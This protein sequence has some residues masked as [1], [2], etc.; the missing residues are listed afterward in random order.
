MSLEYNKEDRVRGLII[1]KRCLY[2]SIQLLGGRKIYNE[3]YKKDGEFFKLI[4]SE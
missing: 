2:K 1:K 3:I 4:K